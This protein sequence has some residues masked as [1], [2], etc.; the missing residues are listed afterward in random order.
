[1]AEYIAL[2]AECYQGIW[3]SRI[4]EDCC[5]KLKKPITVHCENK[6]SIV[7]VKNPV[8]HGRTKHIDVK[9]H[10]IRDLVLEKAVILKY[11]TFEDQLADI[12]T[13]CSEMKQFV[14]F[15]AQMGVYSLQS[16]GSCL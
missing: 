5:V 6:S 12:M 8:L 9:F 14:K 15:R 1:M 11:Y 7:V 10:F 16:R 4:L 2:S 3:L 13:K